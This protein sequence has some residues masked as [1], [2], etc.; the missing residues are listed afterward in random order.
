VLGHEIGLA[1]HEGGH[2]KASVP[3]FVIALSAGA[4]LGLM[5]VVLKYLGIYIP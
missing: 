4:W 3:I 5:L 2:L 1:R